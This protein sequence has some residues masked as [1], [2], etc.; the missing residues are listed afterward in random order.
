MGD[1]ESWC[2]ETRRY[3]GR[4]LI[5]YAERSSQGQSFLTF[6]SIV[7]TTGATDDRQWRRQGLRRA[8]RVGVWPTCSGLFV[9]LQLD[10]G[11]SR[12]G[13]SFYLHGCRS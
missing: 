13:N 11:R 6:V 9:N 12:T 4:R 7:P 10:E 3:R 1:D 8:A 5:S 2:Q